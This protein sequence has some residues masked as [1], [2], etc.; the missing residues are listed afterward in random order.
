VAEERAAAAAERAAV[1]QVGEK[2][3]MKFNHWGPVS[4]PRLE[5]NDAGPVI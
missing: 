2:K 5:T 4:T 3:K 1:G